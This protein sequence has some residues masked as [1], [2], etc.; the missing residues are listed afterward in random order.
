VGFLGAGVI[1]K[2]G[3]TVQGLTT[4]G[5][6]WFSAAIGM[7]IGFGEF[8]LAGIFL[9]TVLFM[10]FFGGFLNRLFKNK[11]QTRRLEFEIKKTNV[12]QKEIILKE[13]G[14]QKISVKDDT[15]EVKDDIIKISAE[16]AATESK[17]KWLENYLLHHEAVHSFSI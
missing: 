15:I 2:N 13:I 5:I 16:I 10:I 7:S 14:K 3:I 4:A 8:F 12:S 11:S 17:I 1:F 9:V 6:I